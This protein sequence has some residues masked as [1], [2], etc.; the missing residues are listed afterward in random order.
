MK[1]VENKNN[2]KSY[3]LRVNRS[4]IYSKPVK[5]ITN[6]GIL[7]YDSRIPL[8]KTIITL[9]E[10][11]QNIINILDQFIC[12]EFNVTKE[13]LKSQERYM[14]LPKARG[15]FTSIL[16]SNFNFPLKVIGM[17]FGGRDHS[18]I[19]MA[20]RRAKEFYKKNG[21]FRSH[22]D[23]VAKSFMGFLSEN[24]HEVENHNKSIT[25]NKFNHYLGFH[26]NID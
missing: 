17:H 1:L 23:R 24:E 2:S 25:G 10:K 15:A 12:S 16:R 14:P 19:L 5:L 20:E 11:G 6:S 18:S 3:G 8:F 9:T 13:E 21:E 26:T 22:Y 4:K 7:N